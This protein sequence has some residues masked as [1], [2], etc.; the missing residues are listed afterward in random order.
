MQAHRFFVTAVALNLIVS[1]VGCSEDPG[2]NGSGG[3][4]GNSSAGQAGSKADAGSGVGGT[5]V[6]GA[7]AGSNSTAG[8]AGEPTAGS[9]AG[10]TSGG[11]AG[12][13]TPNPEVYQSSKGCTDVI[14]DV[15]PIG[16]TLKTPMTAGQ[17]YA[18][19]YKVNGA[20]M[21][22]V[23]IWGTTGECGEKVELL[24][25]EKRDQ[26]TYCVEVHPT[27]AHTHVFS[28]VSMAASGALL[29]AFCANG[30]CP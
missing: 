25:S 30:T 16:Y 2:P 5:A 24:S 23:E 1:A 4:A 20:T 7:A 12:S 21:P 9:G 17:T 3:A 26:G 18:I 29:V 6:G 8:K 27:A 13:C 11:A 22:T 15:I 10:G 28:S 19:S 14:M